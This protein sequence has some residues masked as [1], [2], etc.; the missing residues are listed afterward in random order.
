MPTTTDV[1]LSDAEWDFVC[2]VARDHPAMLSAC[3]RRKRAKMLRRLVRRED[4][5]SSMT[6]PLPLA[7][8]NRALGWVGLG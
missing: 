2:R 4:I 1:R 8:F 5:A 6:Y 7:P 3:P